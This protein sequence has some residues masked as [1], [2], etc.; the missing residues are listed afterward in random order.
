MNADDE[1]IIAHWPGDWPGRRFVDLDCVGDPGDW[2][3]LQISSAQEILFDDPDDDAMASAFAV[4]Y[5]DAGREL[6]FPLPSYSGMSEDEMHETA[7]EDFLGFLR[8]WRKRTL[9]EREAARDRITTET[10]TIAVWDVL[11]EFGFAPDSAVISDLVPGLS[12][13]F[14]NF[15]LSASAVMGKLFRPVVLFTGV[16]AT[17]RT[18]AEVCFELPRM[19]ASR[20][21]LAAF[22][23]YY[24]DKAADR[25][26]FQPA[27]NVGWL[28]MGHQHRHLLPWEVDM[29]TYH[30][31]PHCSVQRDWLRL[32]LKNLAELVAKADDA[33]EVEFGFDGS[34]LAIKCTGQ[35]VPMAASG[36]SWATRFVIPAWKLRH[37]P[38]R[39][40]Q[41]EVEVSVREGR[42]QIG[43]NCFDGAKEKSP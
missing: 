38:K 31:R 13:D 28:M 12:F 33:A 42:L 4:A 37:L 22:L 32:A 27:R 9:A 5:I 2:I 19:V 10:A 6:G 3:D 30:A 7:V 25:D 16:L 17:P 15:T 43:R 40:M 8:E 26:V 35:V 41:G 21:Q 24:L 18:L 14:G 29:A 11:Q 23:A 39:L 1:P 34:V 36:K 20:E